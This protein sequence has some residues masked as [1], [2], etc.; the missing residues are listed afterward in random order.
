MGRNK[1]KCQRFAR[2]ESFCVP[3]QDSSSFI[4]LLFAPQEPG[5]IQALLQHPNH[6][7]Q[8]CRYVQWNPKKSKCT[9]KGTCSYSARERGSKATRTQGSFADL[10]TQHETNNM[11]VELGA[12]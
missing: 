11:R 2:L 12:M 7:D 5:A 4:E 6:I 9:R 1:P 8:A 3:E 10:R